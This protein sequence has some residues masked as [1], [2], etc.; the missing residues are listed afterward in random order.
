M[1]GPPEAHPLQRR[2]SASTARSSS[3]A[4]TAIP[5]GSTAWPCRWPRTAGDVAYEIPF[6]VLEVGQGEAKGTGGPA[7]GSLVYDEE[8]KDI[9]PREVQDFLYAGGRGLRRDLLDLGRRQRLQGPDG[10]SGPLPG[11]PARPARVAA[12]L[13]RRRQLV[14]PG[15]RPPLPLLADEPCRRLAERLPGRHR[16]QRPAHRRRLRSPRPKADLPESLSF[17]PF[18]APNL[19][20]ATMK[21]A[22]T[23]DAVIVRV[24]D[25]EGKDARD[26]DPAA[27]RGRRKPS[28]RT[29]SRSRARSSMPKKG[30]FVLPV[31]HHAVETVR[32]VP[33][34]T[35]A[36]GRG[37]ERSAR[38]SARGASVLADPGQLED[39]RIVR[40]RAGVG[41]ACRGGPRPRGIRH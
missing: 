1:H 9:R 17:L 13:P 27:G 32:L 35:E 30:R 41:Q 38:A 19:A 7:Y 34:G 14:P 36:L 15:G 26:G 18:A 10:R 20:L 2:S 21:K 39:D 16:G 12:E 31:G 37:R 11:A 28:G 3:S 23:D 8:M 6:G 4:S 5:T 40:V 25:I 29:S 24:Y 33:D 22:E